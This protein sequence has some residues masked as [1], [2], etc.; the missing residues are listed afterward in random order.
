MKSFIDMAILSAFSTFA[1]GQFAGKKLQDYSK[2][3]FKRY[4]DFYNILWIVALTDESKSYLNTLEPYIFKVKEI[5]EISIFGIKRKPSFFIKGSG[6]INA[7]YNEIR[8]TGASQGEIII[9]YH[10]VP[11]LR[12]NPP[13]PIEPYRTELDPIGF[14]KVKNGDI[15]SFT[16]YL[17]Y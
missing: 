10:W 8:V 11:S 1:Y 17:S 7:D 4:L 14:I 5:E 3:E 12:T 15:T 13:L 16:I 6:H 2:Q 9:K